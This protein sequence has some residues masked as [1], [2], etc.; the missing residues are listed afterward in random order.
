VFNFAF[1]Y[2]YYITQFPYHFAEKWTYG[3]K[4]I[5]QYVDKNGAKYKKIVI[6][7]RFG[8]VDNSFIGVPSLYILYFNKIDPQAFLDTRSDKNGQF[9]FLKYTVRNVDWTTEEIDRNSLYIVS[10]HSTPLPKQKMNKIYSIN[11]PDGTEA[12]R[13]YQSY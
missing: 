2:R 5:A 9:S 7:P 1:F 13:F 6:D 12:F 11:Y 8:T 4:Q 10:S 3:F